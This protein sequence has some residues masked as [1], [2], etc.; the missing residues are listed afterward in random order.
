MTHEL[1]LTQLQ[2]FKRH[3][4]GT[5]ICFWTRGFHTPVHSSQLE[6]IIET[7]VCAYT[8][9]IFET[10]FRDCG[11]VLRTAFCIKCA[12]LFPL[13]ETT[14]IWTNVLSAFEP[15][16]SEESLDLNQAFSPASA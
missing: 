11:F 9:K 6:F 5:M 15:T 13:P 4:N 2:L 1:P 16:T 8:Q 7:N 3:Q 12:R 14:L 10:D